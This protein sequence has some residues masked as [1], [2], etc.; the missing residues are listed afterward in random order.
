MKTKKMF[1]ARMKLYQAFNA[2]I[3]DR[4]NSVWYFL[5]E[6]LA[7]DNDFVTAKKGP[8]DTFIVS[9][10]TSPA[11]LRNI[12][13]V[14]DSFDPNQY[15]KVLLTLPRKFRDTEDY[16]QH[17]LDFVRSQIPKLCIHR[18]DHDLGPQTKFLGA[19]LWPEL[20]E[21]DTIIVLDD[22]THYKNNLLDS[23]R[24]VL[25]QHETKAVFST[26]P[27]K[28][29]GF[30]VA[31][32][33]RSFCI[34]IRDLVAIHVPSAPSAAPSALEQVRTTFLALNETYKNSSTYCSRHDDMIFASIFQDLGL[35]IVRI[36]PDEYNLQMPEGFLEDALHKTYENTEKNF[37]CSL[38][39]WTTK[40]Q[41]PIDASFQDTFKNYKTA[42]D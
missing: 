26:R 27:Q 7:L 36:G 16:S 32:G 11:R 21:S 20:Q 12:V 37:K 42:F 6:L 31:E 13:K 15:S 29:F 23:Y 4:F 25:A 38:A 9:L 10:T 3:V 24:H 41:C 17:D 30:T 2:C 1:K 8:K 22:D 40:E 35:P 14:L 28:S 33:Y 39:M 5:S 18:I 34:R 19:L